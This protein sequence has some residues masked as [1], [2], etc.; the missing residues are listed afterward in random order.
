M[1][2]IFFVVRSTMAIAFFGMSSGLTLS[3]R[4][5]FVS[6]SGGTTVATPNFESAVKRNALARG[7]LS[8]VAPSTLLISARV[9][10]SWGA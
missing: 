9:S 5:F 7:M 6:A 4:A 10:P 2:S 3:R 8:V 1:V